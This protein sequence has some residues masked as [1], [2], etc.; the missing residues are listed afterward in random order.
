LDSQLVSY[1]TF[2]IALEEVVVESKGTYQTRYRIRSLLGCIT[3]VCKVLTVNKLTW[4]QYFDTIQVKHFSDE[5]LGRRHWSTL[6][7]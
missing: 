3:A 2:T 1:V 7:D 4:Y 6:R 5:I